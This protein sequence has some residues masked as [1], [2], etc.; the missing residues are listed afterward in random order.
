VDKSNS[1][2]II[3]LAKDILEIEMNLLEIVVQKCPPSKQRAVVGKWRENVTRKWATCYIDDN[4]DNEG[5]LMR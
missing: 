1:T 2:F 3:K 4:T 5:S